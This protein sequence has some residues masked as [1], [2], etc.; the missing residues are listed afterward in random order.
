MILRELFNRYFCFIIVKKRFYYIRDFIYYLF[1]YYMYYF[2]FIDVFFFKGFLVN[3]LF[4]W[5]LVDKK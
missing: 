3:V 5:N 4:E 2:N 1:N